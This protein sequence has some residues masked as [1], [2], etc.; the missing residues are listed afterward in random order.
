MANKEL[1]EFMEKI[2]SGSKENIKNLPSTKQ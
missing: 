1:M 2:Q